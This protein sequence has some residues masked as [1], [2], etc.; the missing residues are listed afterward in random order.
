MKNRKSVKGATELL[1]K[2]DTKMVSLYNIALVSS[3]LLPFCFGTLRR[4]RTF[5]DFS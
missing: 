4:C 1:E 2:N 5:L 3:S